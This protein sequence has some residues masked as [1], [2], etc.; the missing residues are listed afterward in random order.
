MYPS[1]FSDMPASQAMPAS[2]F[3]SS[4]YPSSASLTT[5]GQAL[6]TSPSSFSASALP[7][8]GVH[9][10]A[11]V[12]ATAVAD[13]SGVPTLGGTIARM[14]MQ[15]PVDAKRYVGEGDRD[16]VFR[17]LRRDNRT[18]FDCATRNPT[19]LS[20]TYGVYLC[21][22]CSGKHRRLGTHISFVRS[23]EMDKFYPEQL[24]RM[25]MGGNKKAHEFFREHGMDASKAVDYHGKL[26][27]KYKQQLDRAV[28]QEMQTA[29]W[30]IA[31][32]ASASAPAAADA[33]SSSPSPAAASNFATPA[34]FAPPSSASFSQP[35]LAA[36]AQPTSAA[37]PPAPLP[38]ASASFPSAQSEASFAKDR[39]SGRAAGGGLRARKLDFDFDFEAE[40]A[41]AA[42]IAEQKSLHEPA[43]A[44]AGGFGVAPPSSS[45]PSVSG[46]AG[47]AGVSAS[48]LP[49]SFS[50]PGS[51]SGFYSPAASPSAPTGGNTSPMPAAR[52]NPTRF[53]NAKSISSDQYFGTS[54]A[55]R[56][57]SSYQAAITVDPSK[58]SISSDEYFGVDPTKRQSRFSA[59]EDQAVVHLDSLK[60][61]AQQGWATLASVGSDAMSRAR[62][63]LAGS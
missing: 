51:A 40:A 37:A 10:P 1:S 56:A 63:W 28:S 42:A 58:R 12:E 8:S 39:F 48:S 53:S 30:V 22:T 60:A 21:L 5:N 38:R 59:F 49:S 6:A 14:Y 31:S 55:D 44:K 13:A 18:C 46:A 17:R 7:A 35:G 57:S 2:S 25:E 16:E 24:L 9:T 62:D 50:S 41:N 33:S 20:V 52:A 15:M 36:F 3:A 45:P 26:A 34:P 32:A 29:G 19:W 27:A 54:G 23:C 4:S 11:S 61:S 43:H 47:F